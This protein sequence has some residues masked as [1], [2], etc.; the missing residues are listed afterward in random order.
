MERFN[1]L[2]KEIFNAIDVE[3]GIIQLDKIKGIVNDEGFSI[4]LYIKFIDF[5]KGQIIDEKVGVFIRGKNEKI[6]TA[7]P[8]YYCYD[9]QSNETIGELYSCTKWANPT[10]VR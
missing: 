5:I 7:N 1:G 10:E 2:E 9:I 4:E 6:F 3:T 8:Y